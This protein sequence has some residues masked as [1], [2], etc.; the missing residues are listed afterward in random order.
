[1]RTIQVTFKV[2]VLGDPELQSN[3]SKGEEQVE[4]R[5]PEFMLE[6]LDLNTIYT[7]LLESAVS[8]CQS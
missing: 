6:D 2:E 3:P 1:M 7:A 5:V 4:L 8:K